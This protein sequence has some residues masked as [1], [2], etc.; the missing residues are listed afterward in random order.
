MCQRADFDFLSAGVALKVVKLGAT[1]ALKSLS[2]ADPAFIGRQCAIKRTC[3]ADM[4]AVICITLV[5]R[6][7]RV[8]GA[9]ILGICPNDLY[10]FK[11]QHSSYPASQG[12]RR[13][14]V[15]CLEQSAPRPCLY[16]VRPFR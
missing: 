12:M 10:I 16:R 9:Q 2:A 5:Q 3:F 6:V 4:A 8:M 1:F 15:T 13:A 14:S 11:S 7:V